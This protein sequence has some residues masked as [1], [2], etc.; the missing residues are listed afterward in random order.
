MGQPNILFADATQTRKRPDLENAWTTSASGATAGANS[1]LDAGVR[2]NIKTIRDQLTGDQA[3]SNVWDKRVPARMCTATEPKC[4]TDFPHPWTREVT[5]V[6]NTT[7][8]P[9]FYEFWK[10][11]TVQTHTHVAKTPYCCRGGEN[12][13]PA[14]KSNYPH[15]YDATPALM[16]HFPA[17]TAKKVVAKPGKT[18]YDQCF[19][20]N[21]ACVAGYTNKDDTCTLYKVPGGISYPNSIS[22]EERENPNSSFDTNDVKDGKVFIM[23]WDRSVMSGFIRPL[24]GDDWVAGDGEGGAAKRDKWI[25]NACAE[26]AKYAEH[27]GT[28][29]EGTDLKTFKNTCTMAIRKGSEAVRSNTKDDVDSKWIGAST[30]VSA[31]INQLRASGRP[32]LDFKVYALDGKTVETHVVPDWKDVVQ[33]Y[34]TDETIW[35]WRDPETGLPL[36]DPKDLEKMGSETCGFE[37]DEKC[38]FDP[39]QSIATQLKNAPETCKDTIRARACEAEASAN[40]SAYSPHMSYQQICRRVYSIDDSQEYRASSNWIDKLFVDTK[41]FTEIDKLYTGLDGGDSDKNEF[42]DQFKPVSDSGNKDADQKARNARLDGALACEQAI[43]DGAYHQ[44]PVSRQFQ[45]TVK[46]YT[47]AF[48]GNEIIGNN[49]VGQ[50]NSYH[51]GSTTSPHPSKAVWAQ[52]VAHT[53]ALTINRAI[54]KKGVNLSNEGVDVA[55]AGCYRQLGVRYFKEIGKNLPWSLY[56][57]YTKVDPEA[58]VELAV[59]MG[60]EAGFMMFPE[61]GLAAEED[62]ALIKIA[63]ELV[64]TAFGKET[65]TAVACET[66]GSGD[67]DCVEKTVDEGVNVDDLATW[68]SENIVWEFGMAM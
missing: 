63:G 26:A 1:Y 45:S 2:D 4:P 56:D 54:D 36:T 49:Q 60:I 50:W 52:Q 8:K 25:E 7:I 44:E 42:L 61:F 58:G 5:T 62:P 24:V 33:V 48:Q 39:K 38:A 3:P 47:L 14:A 12:V 41:N 35:K 21:G 57:Y 22:Y 66:E 53:C 59:D 31:A 23:D 37:I 55:L 46:P 19:D 64:Q 13:F 15:F 30:A 68:F 17:T 65:A 10:P 51:N 28:T 9:P 27:D 11:D 18:C 43:R 34:M 29:L 67:G 6:T 40:P 20:T 16:Q 32:T